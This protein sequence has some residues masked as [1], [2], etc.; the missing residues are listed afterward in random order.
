VPENDRGYIKKNKK[1]ERKKIFV[2]RNSLNYLVER[3]FRQS[4]TFFFPQI[5]HCV[6]RPSMKSVATRKRESE[7]G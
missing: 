1:K 5:S 6:R 7:K 4:K 2:E 3:A